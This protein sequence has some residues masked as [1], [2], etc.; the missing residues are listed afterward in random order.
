MN[1]PGDRAGATFTAYPVCIIAKCRQSA[2]SAPFDC[3]YAGVFGRHGCEGYNGS[4]NDPRRTIIDIVLITVLVLG[5]CIALDRPLARGDGLAYLMWLDSLARDWDLDLANQAAKFAQVSTYHVFLYE[6]TGHYASVFPFGSSLLLVPFYWLSTW[7]DRLPVMHVNDAYFIQQQG[8]TLAFSFFPMLGTNLYAVATVILA[9]LLTRRFASRAAALVTALALFVGTPLWYYATVEPFS[10]HVAGA[11][12]VSLL[13]YISYQ[14]GILS[15]AKNDKATGLCHSERSEESPWWLWLIAGLAAGLATVVPWQLALCALPLG[16]LLLWRRKGC[17]LAFFA[18][19]FAALAWLVP[20]SW[21][22]MF[23]SPWVIPAAEQ[24]RAAFLLWPAHWVQVL[25]SGEKGLFVWAPLT[26]LAVLGW[27][28]LCRRQ[29]ALGLLL[30]AT[31]GLQVLIN[32]SVY[33]WWAGWGFGMRRMVELYPAFVLGLAALWDARPGAGAWRRLYR[34]AVPVLTLVCTA[35]SVLLLFSH[36]N[37]INTVRD[38]PQ[39]DLAWREVRYQLQDSSWRIT[40]LVIQDHYGP[41]AWHQP[42]P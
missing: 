40:G 38:R 26:A 24:N 25:F 3:T 7:A 36:L 33:D 11:F 28:A 1:N 34:A 19:G 17:A 6:K 31:F 30:A 41:W 27:A 12:C 10:A 14:A 5:A 42:G 23:G 37:F 16:V 18:L 2:K 22:R 39:G 15:A 4:M 9:Y 32:A 13:L 21:W 20:Y 8:L 35:W 29:R